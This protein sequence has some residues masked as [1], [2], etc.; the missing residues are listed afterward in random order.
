MAEMTLNELTALLRECAGEE[1][2]VNLDGDVMDVPFV[3][4]GYDSLAVLQTTGRIELDYGIRI[5]DDAA[6]EAHTPRLLLAFI[7]ESLS[8]ATA[9]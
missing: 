6:A 9:A 5:S 8:E 7:N 2:G 1:E 3:E 4:L